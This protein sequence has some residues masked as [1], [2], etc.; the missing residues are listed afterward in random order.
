MTP[1]GARPWLLLWTGPVF[2]PLTFVH[3]T[4]LA[5][6]AI[7]EVLGLR[8]MPPDY[9]FLAAIRLITPHA[10]LFAMQEMRQYRAVG[11]IGRCGDHRMDQLGAAVDPKMRL[12]PEV[13]LIALP[14][15]MHLGIPRLVGVLGRRGRIDDRRIDD[16]AGGDPQPVGGKMPLHLYEHPLAQ[17][18]RFEPMA[19]TA[20]SGA[21][22]RLLRKLLKKRIQPPRVMITDK[23]AT[24]GAG[25][26]RSCLVSSIASTKIKQQSAKFSP[27]DATTR[28]ANEAVQGCLPGAAVSLRPRSDQQSLPS[29]DCHRAQ[30]R[31][32][33]DLPSV[34]RNQRRCPEDLNLPY[35]LPSHLMIAVHKLTVPFQ[36]SIY[37]SRVP[38]DLKTI[39]MIHRYRHLP[40]YRRRTQRSVEWEIAVE[41]PTMI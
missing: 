20:Y 9:R 17:I 25:K 28:A 26:G 33:A 10:G 30:S 6:A 7:D 29:R 2:R 8:C 18:V 27:A 35:P 38:M 39:K 16:R 3:H 32:D 24:Y 31:Q 34:G 12:H 22:T 15:L 37:S 21:A 11:D 5:V 41:R 40:I 13:P 4:T 1:I 14:C 36:A 19:E 23:L